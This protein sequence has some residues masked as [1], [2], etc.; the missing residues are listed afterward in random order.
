MAWFGMVI[1]VFG[2]VGKG[3]TCMCNDWKQTGKDGNGNG[4]LDCTYEYQPTHSNKKFAN[5]INNLD[6]DV[7]VTT[8]IVT[9]GRMDMPAHATS[10]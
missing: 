5:Y 7:N 2:T 4:Y 8:D 10:S 6:F 9:A 1:P 3:R